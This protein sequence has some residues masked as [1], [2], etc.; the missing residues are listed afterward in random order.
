MKKY[1]VYCEKDGGSYH[2]DYGCPFY[3]YDTLDKE[4]ALNDFNAYKV[5]EI[6]DDGEKTTIYDA[7]SL[8]IKKE[9]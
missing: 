1:I 8:T 7:C 3:K 9:E 4:F 6:T 5:V 2:P